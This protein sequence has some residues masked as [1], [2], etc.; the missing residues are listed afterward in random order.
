MS[1]LLDTD[2]VW[3]SV[4]RQPDENV[5]GWLRPLPNEA[6]FLSVLTLGELRRTVERQSRGRRRERLRVWLEREL[7]AWFGDRLLPVDAG[8]AAR[9]GRLLAEAHRPVPGIDGLV[10]AT[11]LDHRLR[12]VTGREEAF[13]LP[14]L[15]L[16]NPWR[17]A[18]E[19]VPA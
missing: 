10:A 3:E 11:A 12:L 6:L 13:A 8:V 2:V 5:I 9:W 4:R 16:V 14:G 17:P 15:E 19:Q 7:S 1:Y 18:E